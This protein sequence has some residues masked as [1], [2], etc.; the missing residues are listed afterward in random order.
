[1]NSFYHR[2]NI[3][4]IGVACAILLCSY[5][6]KVLKDD[7]GK[8]IQ[9]HLRACFDSS[10]GAVKLKK[11]EISL[12]EK[13]FFRLRKFYPNGKQEYYSFNVRRFNDLGYLGTA[14]NGEIIIKTVSD[15]IIVQTYNDPKGNIDSMSAKLSIPVVNVEPEMLDSLK[16]KLFELKGK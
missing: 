14:F 5:T 10:L 16:S 12:S 1:M 15:D 13:G 3:V 7:E 6:F 11:W 9:D 2:K 4:A 8:W